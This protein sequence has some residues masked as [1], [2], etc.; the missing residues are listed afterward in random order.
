MGGSRNQALRFSPG[1][2]ACLVTHPTPLTTA[3]LNQL[4]ADLLVEEL[5][6]GGV[7]FF[8]LSPGSRSTP[9]TVAVAKNPRARH[10]MH[11]DER[12]SAFVALGYARATGKPACWIT[13]SGT[14]LANGYPAIVEANVDG[15]PL[16]ALTADRP[17]ELRQSAA[18]QTIDQPSIFADQVRWK[19]DIPA[20]TNDVA[21]TFLQ[22]LAA[23]A[24]HRSIFPP[25]PIHLN[26]M[27]REPFVSDRQ[28]D[29]VD[30]TPL[31][32]PDGTPYTRYSASVSISEEEG[33]AIADALAGVEKGLVI[34]GRLKSQEDSVATYALAEKLGWPL[35]ADVCSGLRSGPDSP[36]RIVAAEYVLTE[37]F[38]ESHK[39]EA[40]VY[41][42]APAVSKRLM[43]FL[44]ASQPDIYMV[45]HEGPQRIDPTH[46]ATDRFQCSVAA[47]ATATSNKII[48]RAPGD[49]LQSWRSASEAVQ[50][51][52]DGEMNT[53]TTISEP[54][55]A[56]MLQ[57]VLPEEHILVVASSM[58]IRDL[59]NCMTSGDTERLIF[60]NR[61]AS[62]ID[63]TIATAVGVAAALNRPL[64]VLIGD[65]ALLHDLNSLALLRNPEVPPITVIAI[66]NDG[67]AIF[68]F[69][70]IA[71]HE[72]VFEPMFGTPH[73][74]GFKS[75]AEMFGLRYDNPVTMATF[76]S[77]VGEHVEDGGSSIIE[78]VT[79]RTE[80][81]ILHQRLRNIVET[82][83]ASTTS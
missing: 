7:D 60:A 32:R 58:P 28:E 42:G 75:T 11:F 46:Q 53:A 13:T 2:I 78:V 81:R 36:N 59:D 14:A 44:A 70:P 16:I 76:R 40:V 79:D 1:D 83:V 55:V 21:P 66:N 12:G 10:I 26:A 24:I 38:V 62:G 68:T 50:L 22:T 31:L 8:C 15:V 67:G 25:G 37:S 64:S 54:G 49:W 69:L 5:L 33:A 23:Q 3:Q 39:P 65:L 35:I 20:P 80:N 57:E 6:R 29:R 51:V 4:W 72:S 34:A 77:T 61:G 52:L 45:A 71:E 41:L 48:R 9:L 63:G 19:S 82:A 74:M 27:F 18:N 73:G 17:P 43:Q 47:W 30:I 56:R